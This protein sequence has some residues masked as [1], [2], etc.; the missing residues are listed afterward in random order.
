[1]STQRPTLSVQFAFLNDGTLRGI[2][3]FILHWWSAMPDGSLS[4]IGCKENAK[5]IFTPGFVPGFF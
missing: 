4:V 5:D 3:F 2:C 1:M